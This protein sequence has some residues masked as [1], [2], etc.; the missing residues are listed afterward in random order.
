MPEECSVQ[1]Q[2]RELVQVPEQEQVVPIHQALLEY[3]RKKWML[4]TD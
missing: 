2:V 4:L 1:E 3:L